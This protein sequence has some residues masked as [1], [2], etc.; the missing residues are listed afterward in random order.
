MIY[1]KYWLKLS[2]R[3]PKWKTV[4]TQIKG[5]PTKELA[6]AKGQDLIR[7]NQ[8]FAFNLG[9]AEIVAT[10]DKAG[11]SLVRWDK[12]EYVRTKCQTYDYYKNKKGHLAYI[13]TNNL[14]YFLETVDGQPYS[15]NNDQIVFNKDF[16][17]THPYNGNKVIDIENLF[18][19]LENVNLAKNQKRLEQNTL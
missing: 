3:H 13:A 14:I 1:A 16:V 19:E 2:Y 12:T 7:N 4:A 15:K 17:Q 10:G 18:T 8:A 9:V 6:S 5:F 11:T